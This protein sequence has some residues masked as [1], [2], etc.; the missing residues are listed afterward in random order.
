MSAVVRLDR[1]GALAKLVIDRPPVN[2]LDVATMKAV[3]ECLDAVARDRTIKVLAITGAGKAFAAGV[4]VAD[5]T[6]ERV[7]CMLRTFHRMVDRIRTVK[8]PVV[9]LVQGA[10]MGG[11]FELALACDVLLAR[12]DAKLGLPEIKLGVFPPVAAALLPR[13]V[14]RQR[15][16]DLILRG[17]TFSGDEAHRLGLVTH[18]WPA[19]DYCTGV[20]AYLRDLMELSGPALRLAKRAVDVGLEVPFHEALCRAE[21]IYRRDVMALEDAREGLA[22]FIEKRSPVWTEA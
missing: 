16:L 1:D 4:D 17:C 9:A 3:S 8:I 5:H 13:I 11:G 22:A 19:D 14:G 6:E 21:E 2:V 12:S 7:E 20:A 15:A 10:A 18:A